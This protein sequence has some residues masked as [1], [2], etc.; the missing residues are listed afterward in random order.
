MCK[1]GVNCSVQPEDFEARIAAGYQ[2]GMSKNENR[3]SLKETGLYNN[4]LIEL[5]IKKTT[6]NATNYPGFTPGRLDENKLS[7]TRTGHRWATDGVKNIQISS[8]APPPEGFVLGKAEHKKRKEYPTGRKWYTNGVIQIQMYTG[9]DIPVGFT[10]GRLPHRWKNGPPIIT[11][12]QRQAVANSNRL[13]IKQNKPIR[14][15]QIV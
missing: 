1:G 12:K 10:L 2:F 11:E 8:D 13:R 3:E 5:R 7:A 9:A 4:G 15:P 6:F 14:S